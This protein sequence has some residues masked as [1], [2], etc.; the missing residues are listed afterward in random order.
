MIERDLIARSKSS[1]TMKDYTTVVHK[2]WPK[3]EGKHTSS[4]QSRLDVAREQ[5]SADQSRDT[6]NFSDDEFELPDIEEI[7]KWSLP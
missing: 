1:R 5:G 3:E 2:Y 7:F 6:N 4:S